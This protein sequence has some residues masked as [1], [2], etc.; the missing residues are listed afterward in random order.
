MGCGCA[1]PRNSRCVI[2][3][4]GGA[5]GRCR[6]D[7]GQAAGERRDDRTRG[8]SGDGV[9]RG[10][11]RDEVACPVDTHAHLE[12]QA[13]AEVRGVLGAELLDERVRSVAEA[14]ETGDVR[15]FAEHDT[16][17]VRD[18]VGGSV[19]VEDCG[20]AL[21]VAVITLF[22]EG[23]DHESEHGHLHGEFHGSGSW[24]GPCNPR[25]LS[26]TLGDNVKGGRDALLVKRAYPAVPRYGESSVC[27]SFFV[28]A[29]TLS[30]V[31]WEGDYSAY[32]SRKTAV[33]QEKSPIKWL[34]SAHSSILRSKTC[35]VTGNLIGLAAMTRKK[36]IIVGIGLGVALLAIIAGIAAAK[37]SGQSVFETTTVMRGAVVKT[38]DISGNLAKSQDVSLAFATGGVVGGIPVKIGST[39]ATGDILMFLT[40]NDLAANLA[41]AYASLTEAEANYAAGTGGGSVEERAQ[42]EAALVNAQTAVLQTATVQ[43]AAV[44]TAEAALAQARADAAANRVDAEADIADARDAAVAAVRNAVTAADSVLGIEN[45]IA[46][47]EFDDY[48][49]NVNPQAMNDARRAFA[50]AVLS[51]DAAEVS[52][53]DDMD[54]TIAVLDTAFDDATALLLT[55]AQVLEGTLMDTREFSADDL[56]ALK[57]SVSASR[58][59]LTSAQTAFSTATQSY[60]TTLRAADAAETNAAYALTTA[61]AARDQA[62]ASAV[63]AVTAREADLAAIT[64]GVTGAKAGALAAAVSRAQAQRD[65]A[66]AALENAQIVAPIDGVVTD[67]AADVG[68]YVTPGAPVMRIVS[69]SD[70]FVV[71]LDVAESDVDE[72]RGGQTAHVTVDAIGDVAFSGTVLSVAGAEKGAGEGAVFY[73]AEVL[74][75]ETAEA[76]RAGMSVDVVVDVDRREDVLYVPQRA[77]VKRDG[78]QFIR[79]PADNDA[80]YSELSVTVG[81]RGD[82]GLVEI[83]DGLV[84]GQT[85]I[86]RTK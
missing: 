27:A 12:R 23:E 30:P 59:T 48:L 82:D 47:D 84:E 37:K 54:V 42:A 72:I 11:V 15:A 26:R 40:A 49:A 69:R 61:Q 2:E 3:N 46:N 63:G 76:M 33:C 18:R 60:A 83:T 17:L 50:A 56:E 65:A 74:L 43:N 66:L 9:R 32:S 78:A 85:I 1:G 7:P 53:M 14:V 6:F 68:E 5:L 81:M 64:T 35:F 25:Y 51:R 4:S 45:T 44:A 21:L 34:I 20:D 22:R 31:N 8:A 55:V 10:G 70:A 80:G 41:V 13:S 67:I 38:V 57:A 29:R 24:R 16:V 36:R 86:V 73:E 79:V 77:V 39:V 28:R 71:T 19:G 58:T 52:A 75:L 62:N